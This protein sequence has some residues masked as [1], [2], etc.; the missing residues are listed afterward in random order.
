MQHPPFDDTAVVLLSPDGGLAVT[1]S[2]ERLTP[3]AA[4]AAREPRG[5]RATET[6][7]SGLEAVHLRT[8]GDTLTVA[9]GDAGSSPAVVFTA[10]AE[11]GDVRPYTRVLAQLING[12]ALPPVV[13]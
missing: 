10:H 7:G 6:L 8:I 1:I 2:L 11:D 12:T 13:P 5:V 3:D 9:V 4:L